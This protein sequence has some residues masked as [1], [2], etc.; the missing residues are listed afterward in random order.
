MKILNINFQNTKTYFNQSKLSP[1]YTLKPSFDT[2]SFS[3]KPKQANLTAEGKNISKASHGIFAQAQ[4]IQSSTQ[5][6]FNKSLKIQL[7]SQII[8]EEADREWEELSTLLSDAKKNKTRAISDPF[9]KTDMFFDVNEN[10]ETI[11]FHE[12]KNDKLTRKVVQ[13]PNITTI[14]TYGDKN[15]RKI[16]D[17]KS[18]TLIKYDYNIVYSE[19][20]SSSEH[21]YSFD[22]GLLKRYSHNKIQTHENTK[23]QFAYD[24][25]NNT[26]TKVAIAPFS[27]NAGYHSSDEEYAFKNGAL[28]RYSKAPQG[29]DGSYEANEE[30]YVFDG[31]KLI[32]TKNKNDIF[33]VILTADTIYQIDNAK[34]KKATISLSQGQNTKTIDKLFTFDKHEKPQYCYLVY[35]AEVDD[36][37]ENFSYDN[38]VWLGGKKS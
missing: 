38:M 28:V 4:K 20:T 12:Y 36:D 6:F 10:K 15:T 26:L 32:Y 18:G 3:A 7:Q 30:E 27:T 2:I 13:R 16:F 14:S 22:N 5:D 33:D 19:N 31:K 23:A 1:I 11:T 35:Q 37:N 17:S 34:I 29:E 25:E 24:F 21:S 8:L 9:T